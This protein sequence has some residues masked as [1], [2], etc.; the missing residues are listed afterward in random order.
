[1]AS[2]HLL[3]NP[4]AVVNRDD[5]GLVFEDDLELSLFLVYRYEPLL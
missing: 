3:A 4:I 1:V 2:T 5:N